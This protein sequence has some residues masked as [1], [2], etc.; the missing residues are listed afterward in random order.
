MIHARP[1]IRR[2][3]LEEVFTDIL[4]VSGGA[5]GCFAAVKARD[6]GAG[7]VVW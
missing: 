3:W 2:S 1:C 4:V 6:S 5:A 7:K